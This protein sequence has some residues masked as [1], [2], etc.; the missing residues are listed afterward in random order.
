MKLYFS[1]NYN[2]RLGLATAR[3][4]NA[5]VE[6]EFASPFAPDQRKK[7]RKLNPNLSI[8]ILVEDDG[9]SLWEADAI[10]CRLSQVT[11]SD[12]WR[13]GAGQ[14]EM[15]KWL[16][17]GMWNFV[18]ACDRVH[19][20]R[21]TKQRYGQGPILQDAVESGLDEF[22]ASARILGDVLD[23]QDFLLPDGISYADFRMACVLPYADIA[24]LPLADFPK[25]HAWHERLMQ[26]E[27][28]RDP[29]AG[30]DVPDLPPVPK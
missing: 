21:V 11:G 27:A 12:F 4:L 22:A 30:M 28:W 5:P 7:F 8:P 20:E 9:T 6:Y 2:P 15:I 23:G 17:W 26:I 10:A 3:Y 16:S 25:V 29:F 18:R 19:Y 1:R 13:T 24:G 14:P